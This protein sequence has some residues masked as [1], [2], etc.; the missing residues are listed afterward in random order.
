MFILNIIG[1]LALIGLLGFIIAKK[2]LLSNATLSL[3][4]KY[5]F[6]Y[7]IPLFLFH[8][9]ATA[10]I[11]QQ[12]DW[13]YFACFYLPV[14]LSYGIAWLINHN[15]HDTLKGN[16][17]ASAV[18][19]LSASYSN[20]VIIGLPILLTLLG[21]Q[22]IGVI[23]MIITFHSALLF[24]LTTSFSDGS[25][26][27]SIWRRL[28]QQL[29]KNPLVIAISS[30]LIVNLSPI[31]IPASVSQLVNLLN[32]PTITL[33]LMLLGA[34]LSQ[35]RLSE[36]KNFITMASLIKL[37]LLPFIVLCFSRMIFNLS[38]DMVTVLVIL[39]ACPTGVN[40]YLIASGQALHKSTVAGVV[41]V[42]TLC[43]LITLP[44]WLLLLK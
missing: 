34:S 1:P 21:E 4:S 26:S 32:W 8:K 10:N 12:F 44:L 28:H 30:G 33:A 27:H 5:T 18:F 41:V 15:W 7:L 39:S 3:V 13:R 42:S 43:S 36:Q 35:Y 38:S 37:L 2:Q 40:A 22:V 23:F 16:A 6:N 9:M 25:N 14:L 24:T 20:T 17:S 11:Q 31:S 29:T 19:A